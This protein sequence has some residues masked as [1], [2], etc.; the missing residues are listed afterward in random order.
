[1]ESTKRLIIAIVLSVIVWFVWMRFFSPEKPIKKD[2]NGTEITDNIN[3]ANK[4][5]TEAEPEIKETPA[6]INLVSS[7]ITETSIDVDTGNFKISLSNKGGV[8]KNFDYNYQG[9]DIRLTVPNEMHKTEG[10]F[11]FAIHFT[12]NEFLNGNSL[13]DTVWNYEKKSDTEIMFYTNFSLNGNPVQLQKSYKFIKQ[14]NYFE[15]EYNLI[16]PGNQPVVLPNGYFIVSPA[17]FLGPDMDFNNR[18]NSLSQIY[19]LNDDFSKGSKGGGFFSKNG[20]VKKENGTAKWAGVMSRYFLLIMLA[21]D[22]GGNAVITDSRKDTGYRSGIIIPA[23]TIQPKNKITKSFKVYAGEKNKDKLAAVDVSLKDAA[24][25]SKWIEP[26]RDVLMWCLL[27][28]NI[29]FG[30]FGWSLVVFSILTKIILLPLTQRS[31]E[32]MRRMQSLT[33]Q[34]NELKAKY[35]DKPDQLN[36]EMMKLYRANKV[37]PLGGCLPMVI[38]MPFFIAL[39]SALLNAVELWQ[40]PFIFWIKDLSMPDTVFTISGFDINILPLIMTGATFLQQKMT[41]GSQAGQQ[42][43][44]MMLMPLIFIFIFWT[45]PSGL[46]LYWTLQNLL[47]VAHQLYTNRKVDKKKD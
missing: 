47:Q 13:N 1:M 39:Y 9:K 25:V 30:N 38:Q 46:V 15:L 34:M 43:K 31:T 33:P 42:Q 6:A 26:I 12:E 36:K 18:Y 41:P 23:V 32:S 17:D 19:Y 4:K 29:V 37:N 5:E 10:L 2:I 7:K 40:A 27:K 20:P 11:D 24:D 21:N 35:K 8:I 44:M 14:T 16:N 22:S 28:I 45:M 3:T